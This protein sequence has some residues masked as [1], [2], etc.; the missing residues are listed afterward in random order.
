M[1]EVAWYRKHGTYPRQRIR[2][3]ADGVPYVIGDQAWHK[4]VPR[5]FEPI[6]SAMTKDIA[7]HVAALSAKVS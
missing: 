7:S 1:L 3:D 2:R 4:A 5:C 6:E